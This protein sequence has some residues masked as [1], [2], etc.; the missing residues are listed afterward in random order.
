MPSTDEIQDLQNFI[1]KL[2]EDKDEVTK[3]E[4]V[5]L[6]DALDLHSDLIELIDLLPGKGYKRQNI[7]DQ[8]NSSISGHGWGYV[9]GT[10]Q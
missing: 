2:F 3:I 4:V 7:C 1:N 9:W 10:V 5:A 6:A 8:L